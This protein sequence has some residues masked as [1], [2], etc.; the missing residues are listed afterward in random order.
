MVKILGF[1]PDQP[2]PITKVTALHN[3]VETANLRAIQFLLQAGAQVNACDASLS[4]PL[5]IAAYM[6]HEEVR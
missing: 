2:D 1:P 5:H 6:G 3:A 4:T